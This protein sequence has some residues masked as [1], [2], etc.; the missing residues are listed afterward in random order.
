MSVEEQKLVNTWLFASE[1]NGMKNSNMGK[2]LT[3]IKSIKGINKGKSF[4]R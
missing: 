3:H 2:N 4:F 1:I